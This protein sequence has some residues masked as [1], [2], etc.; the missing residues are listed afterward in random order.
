MGHGTYSC[1]RTKSNFKACSLQFL[2]KLTRLN[3]DG[4]NLVQ[5]PSDL[6]STLEELKINENH[7][8]GIDEDSLSG[9]EQFLNDISLSSF[10]YSVGILF[11]ILSNE[12]ILNI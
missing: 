4:N 1:A 11:T 7:L 10:L 5:I 12:Y 6:P 8:Q 9:I 3:L 2:K